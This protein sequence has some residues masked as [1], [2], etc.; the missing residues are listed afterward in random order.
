MPRRFEMTRR[1]PQSDPK[2]SASPNRRRFS[3]RQ[4]L[5]A[6]AIA[7]LAIAAAVVLAGSLATLLIN[8]RLPP[9]DSLLDY[10]PR[11]PLRILT[12][13]GV[14]IG[15]FGEERRTFVRIQDVPDVM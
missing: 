15:E 10:K 3:F 11:I 12:A 13:D 8:D 6:L 4:L 1:L 9:L 2:P 14:L 7:P 5:L